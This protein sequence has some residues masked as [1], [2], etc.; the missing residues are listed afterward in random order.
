MKKKCFLIK[1]RFNE[2]NL[3]KLYFKNWKWQSCKECFL[4]DLTVDA[5]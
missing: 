5:R 3:L 1:N 4:F 2:F